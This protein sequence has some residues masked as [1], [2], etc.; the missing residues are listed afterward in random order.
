MDGVLDGQESLQYSVSSSR[1]QRCDYKVVGDPIHG[2]MQIPLYCYEFIDSKEF[3]RLRYLKQLGTTSFVYP[4]ATHTRFEHSQGVAHLSRKVIARIQHEQPE[5]HVTD[6]EVKLITIAG[7]CHD[8]GHG[9]FSHAFEHWIKPKVGD[10]WSHEHQSM[11][12]V[13]RIIERKEL[14]YT[15]REVEMIQTLIRGV[16]PSRHSQVHRSF[17]Y[18]IV[19]NK[20][21]GIDVDKFDYLQRDARFTTGAQRVSFNYLMENSRVIGDQLCF[22]MNCNYEI[23]QLFHERFSMFK[24][25]YCHPVGNAIEMMICD[26]FDAADPVLKIAE[27]C[28]SIDTYALLN[29]SLLNRIEDTRDEDLRDAQRILGRLRDRN[30]Y[31]LCGSTLFHGDA[32]EKMKVVDHARLIASHCNSASITENDIVCRFNKFDYG[33]QTKNPVDEVSFFKGWGPS[34]ESFKIPQGETSHLLPSMFM[35]F[36][37]ACYSKDPSKAKEVCMCVCV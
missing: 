33:M 11:A 9:P 12:L 1:F 20:R 6:K 28:E 13:E 4:S 17:L 14:N 37:L 7:L 3:Q 16:K 32:Y 35:E 25:V 26:I 18:E 8:L 31:K 24:Q 30:L 36:H 15:K 22:H 10:H 19:A 34:T 21:N 23:Y 2:H 5:L 29:D 27:Q